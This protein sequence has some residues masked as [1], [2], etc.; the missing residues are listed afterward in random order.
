[1]EYFET[2]TQI[3]TPHSILL[4]HTFESRRRKDIKFSVAKN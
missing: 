4:I 2:V 3:V 1:M